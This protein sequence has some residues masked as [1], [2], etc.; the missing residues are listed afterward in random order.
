MTLIV[1]DGTIVANSN[2][3]VDKTFII[4]YAAD[5]GVI[6]AND[7]PNL[8]NQIHLFMDFLEAQEYEAART[9]PENQNLAFPRTG[10]IIDGVEIGANTIPSILKKVEAEGVLLIRSGFDFAPLLEGNIKR[11]KFDVFEV[12]YTDAGKRESPVPTA[13]MR[14]LRKLLSGRSGLIRIKRDYED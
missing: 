9:D 5:R 8:E 6:I 4:N 3:Y 12:E 2:T 1:E 13:V 7:D 10:L 11:E 14:Y